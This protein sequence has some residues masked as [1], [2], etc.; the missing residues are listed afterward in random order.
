MNVYRKA[1]RDR[2]HARFHDPE[3]RMED[4]AKMTSPSEDA[5]RRWVRR[6]RFM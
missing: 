2:F 1:F 3:F 4:V 5:S 6:M